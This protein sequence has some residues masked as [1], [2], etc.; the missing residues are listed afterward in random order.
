MKIRNVYIFSIYHACGF[1]N[2]INSNNKQKKYHTFSLSIA[3]VFFSFLFFFSFLSPFNTRTYARMIT[4]ETKK[5]G[6]PG[7]KNTINY[8]CCPEPYVDITFT[9]QIRRRTLY[10]F[11]NLIVPCVL[12][13]SMALLGFTLPPDSGEKLT[14]GMYNPS[15]FIHLPANTTL[16]KL[17][18]Y[19][20]FI[21][22]ICEQCVFSQKLFTL[23]IL[24]QD[25]W[26]EKFFFRVLIFSSIS[27]FSNIFIFPI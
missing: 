18:L 20:F 25:I 9:I 27:L 12:I 26:F 3:S 4:N 1:S 15:Q 6:M 14:L 21:S 8:A 13:S 11:F 22:K 23:H 10:Y 5:T 7:I 17:I 19:F 24:F 16:L 2:V